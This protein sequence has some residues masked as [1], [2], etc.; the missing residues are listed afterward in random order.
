MKS[1]ASRFSVLLALF[2]LSGSGCLGIPGKAQ[3]MSSDLKAVYQQSFKVV[4]DRIEET[5]WLPDALGED[6]E[7]EKV[8]WQQELHQASSVDQ[9]RGALRGLLAGL[10]LSHFGITPGRAS[11]G[12]GKGGDA[13]TG[14]VLR[15]GDGRAVVVKVKA[16]SPAQKAGLV[17]GDVLIQ[18]G[19]QSLVELIEIWSEG[20]NRYLPVQGLASSMLGSAGDQRDYTIEGADGVVRKVEITLE[21]PQGT[22]KPVQF[23]HIGPIPL[24]LEERIV[25]GG[26]LYLH[27]NMFLGPMQ[28]MPWFENALKKNRDAPG[29]V[30]DL[31]GN[32]GGLG[33]M[34]CGI[35][36][37]LLEEDHLELGVMTTRNTQMR[38]VVNPRLD[39]WT[40]P[41]ALLIDEGSASTAEILAQGLQDLNR[42]RLFGRTTA[43]A[44]LPSKIES[45]PCGDLMQYAIAGYRSQSGRV[46]EGDGV[47]PDEVIAVDAKRIR[48]Q[49]DPELAAALRWISSLSN[50]VEGVDSQRLDQ[51]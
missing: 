40:K 20:G 11:E 19:D 45:L 8:R 36:G 33:L 34:A 4:C 46:L 13:E 16:D 14:A 3:P 29:L 7:L 28:V 10:E 32:P 18:V 50:P 47:V 31:R 9:A 30:I 15:V 44:A 26:V 48:K 2:V 5:Y 37:W 27:F 43:G 12:L 51:E 25:A 1:S 39:P 38:F 41:V 35:A 22:G 6:W 49:G 17:P 42:A 21:R 24:V 23:G